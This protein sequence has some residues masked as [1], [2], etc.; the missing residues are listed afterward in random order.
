MDPEK[1]EATQE[2]LDNNPSLAEAG[3][4]VGDQIEVAEDGTTSKASTDADESGTGG[5][6]E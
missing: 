3:V 2:D 6:S 4:K 1:R 5:Q